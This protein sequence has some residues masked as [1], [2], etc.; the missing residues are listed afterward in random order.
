MHKDIE[1]RKESIYNKEYKIVFLDIDG[2]IQ[3]KKYS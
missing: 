2:V 3:F 1:F